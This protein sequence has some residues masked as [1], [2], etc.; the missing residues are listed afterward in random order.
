MGTFSRIRKMCTRA[1]KGLLKDRL[2]SGIFVCLTIYALVAIDLETIYGDKDSELV[3]SVI[4][5]VVFFSFLV[6]FSLFSLAKANYVGRLPFWLDLLAVASLFPD[7]YV[8]KHVMFPNSQPSL[9]QAKA[10]AR[11]TRTFR[12]NRVIRIIRV[13][14]LVPRM[15]DTFLKRSNVDQ[16][17]RVLRQKLQRVFM[18][19]D[20]DVAG[21]VPRST[22][23]LC[24]DHIRGE[25]TRRRGP[26]F[27]RS[28][29]RTALGASLRRLETRTTLNGVTIP[30]A[31]DAVVDEPI[32]DEAVDFE[33]FQNELLHDELVAAYL[34]SSCQRQLKK[35]NNMANIGMRQLEDISMKVAVGV[36]A[37][38]VVLNVL[39]PVEQDT[40]LQN[41]L[42]FMDAEVEWKLASQLYNSSVPEFV[43]D[44]IE[45][46]MQNWPSEDFELVYLD[47]DKR[48]FCNEFR[49]HG[50]RCDPLVLDSPRYWSERLSL[51]DI[52]EDMFS[53]QYRLRDLS[54]H[55][56]PDLE[57][58]LSEEEVNSL[59][60]AVAVVNVRGTIN[61]Q[62]TQLLLTTGVVVVIIMLGFTSIARDMISLR[63]SLLQPLRNLADE[64]QSITQRQLAGVTTSFSYEQCAAEIRLIQTTFDG[65]KNAMKSWGKYVPWQVVQRLLQNGVKAD[66]F[67]EELEVTL[68]FSDIAS[69]TTIVEAMDPVDAMVLLSQYFSEMSKVIEANEGIVLEFIGDAIFALFGAPVKN[70][71]HASSAVRATLKMLH[72]LRAINAWSASHDFPQL[73]IRCGVHTGT[74]LVGNI[75]LQSRIKY[76]VVGDNSTIPPRLEELNKAYGT[77]NLFSAQTHSRLGT[78]SIVSRPVDMVYLRPRDE[79]PERVYQALGVG[80]RSGAG[81]GNLKAAA[82]LYAV[83][84]DLYQA[85]RFEEAERKFGLAG[86]RLKEVLDTDD[87]PSRVMQERCREYLRQPPGPG[88]KGVWDGA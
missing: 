5:T 84:L 25:E 26:R 17:R 68:F 81:G 75:G 56:W 76:G 35:G 79:Q 78:S 86:A 38:M 2:F 40:A 20:L 36:L 83:A 32:G 70:E 71:D 67:V 47:L 28:S 55:T 65:M 27:S 82:N 52:D 15:A 23:Q 42:A 39:T 16:V 72:C 60:S 22:L 63:R 50:Q 87:K 21:T 46:W 58:S 51:T 69:F 61:M 54:F 62:S 29:T 77:D 3:V 57:A 45:V 34:R 44:H 8:F 41:G 88:W 18:A 30:D 31:S 73:Q 7:T 64:M 14:T 59:T 12:I 43:T 53:S 66:I 19:V 85:R 13:V 10:A 48:V 1:T 80:R 24:H 49:E 4:T 74:C 37:M 9:A 11:A 33:T 6:E